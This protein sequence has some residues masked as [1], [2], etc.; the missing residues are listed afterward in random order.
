MGD[1]LLTYEGDMDDQHKKYKEFMAK[2]KE[3]CNK[4]L[5]EKIEV[6]QELILFLT[7]WLFNH[8]MEVDKILAKFLK[9]KGME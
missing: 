7:N 6:S 1:A 4:H 9:E 5:V 8:I 3:L 2:L